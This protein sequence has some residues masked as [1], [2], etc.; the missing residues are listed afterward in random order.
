MERRLEE[1]GMHQS[2]S[3]PSFVFKQLFKTLSSEGKLID[4]AK[5]IERKNKNLDMDLVLNEMLNN[6]NQY[7]KEYDKEY[8]SA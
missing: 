4:Y 8:E 1:A 7:K 6:L 3:G 2:W 5:M